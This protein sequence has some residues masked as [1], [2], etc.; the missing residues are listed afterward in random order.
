MKNIIF[1]MPKKVEI[2]FYESN[3][4]ATL[5]KEMGL[6]RLYRIKNLVIRRMLHGLLSIRMAR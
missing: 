2:G 1:Q 6:K 5:I 3:G 4:I